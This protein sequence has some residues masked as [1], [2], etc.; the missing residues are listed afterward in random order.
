MVNRYDPIPF[1]P[2]DTIENLYSME[3]DDGI[4]FKNTVDLVVAKNRNKSF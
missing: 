1:L 4:Y 3:Q 2:K